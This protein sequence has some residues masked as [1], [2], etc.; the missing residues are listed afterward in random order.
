MAKERFTR[1]TVT[2][3]MAALAYVLSF[4]NIWALT[5]RLGVPRPITPLIAPMVDLSVVGRLI[6]LHLLA[7]RGDVTRRS[8]CTIGQCYGKRCGR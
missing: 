2:V 3:V 1:S 7:L 8:C 6:A 4:S 5:L